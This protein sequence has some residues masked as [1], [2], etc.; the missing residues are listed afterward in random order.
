M[1]EKVFFTGANQTHP[2]GF[3]VVH[4]LQ[5][6]VTGPIR[7]EVEGVAVLFLGNKGS[8]GCRLTQVRRLRWKQLPHFTSVP[9]TMQ[10][11]HLR[12]CL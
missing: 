4:G 3:N 10:P 9:H 1:G 6:E 8:M 7:G 12:T 2:S 5:G 11:S